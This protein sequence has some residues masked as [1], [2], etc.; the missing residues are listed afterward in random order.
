MAGLYYLMMYIGQWTNEEQM[1][2]VQSR[3]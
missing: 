2:F 1:L 3:R